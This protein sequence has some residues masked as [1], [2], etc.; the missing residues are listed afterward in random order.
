MCIDLKNRTIEECVKY[1]G[2]DE[3]LKQQ[4]KSYGFII[5]YN[6]KPK[7]IRNRVINKF[8]ENLSNDKIVKIYKNCCDYYKISL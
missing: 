4:K 2:Y 7:I 1:D 6:I 8:K 3:W 5:K